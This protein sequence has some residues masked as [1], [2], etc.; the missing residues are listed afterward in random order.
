LLG[1]DRS[2]AEQ[3]F[4]FAA[5]EDHTDSKNMLGVSIIERK[6][7]LRIAQRWISTAAREGCAAAATNLTSV[8]RLI[9]NTQ[10]GGMCRF[11]YSWSSTSASQAPV[12][13][14]VQITGQRW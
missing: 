2:K 10:V 8:S 5:H 13:F 6:G 11:E 1:G 14:I 12:G 3:C 7:D 4:G 9:D